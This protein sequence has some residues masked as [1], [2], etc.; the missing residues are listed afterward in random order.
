MT[1]PRRVT[2][3]GIPVGIL[4]RAQPW[5]SGPVRPEGDPPGAARA[6]RLD[7][8]GPAAPLAGGIADRA[9]LE[10]TLRV[11]AA[12]ADAVTRDE[13][14]DAIVAHVGG[15]VG[16]SS[17]AVFLV[18]D[19]GA[20]AR[21]ARTAGY[22]DAARERL[23][24]LPLDVAGRLPALDCLRAGEPLWIDSQAALLERYPHL[25][26]LVTPGRSYRIACLPLIGHGATLGALALTFDDAPALD[27]EERAFLLLCAR[28]SAQAVERLRLHEAERR[29]RERAELLYGLVHEVIVASRAEDVFAAALDAIAR[30]LGAERASILTYGKDP[31]MRFRAWRG[32]SDAY[33]AAVDGHS[34]WTR[35]IRDPAPIV[36]ADVEADPAAAPYRSIFRAE[37][38]GALAFIPLVAGRELVGKFMVYYPAPRA[39][40]ADEL[41]LARAI[42]DHVAA[43]IARFAAVGELEDAIRFND[44]FIAILGH[45]LRNPLAAI[46]TAAQL[47]IVRGPTEAMRKPLS[48]IVASGLRMARMIEQ[49]LDLTRV[50]AGGGIPV[51]AAD[52]DLVPVARAVIDEIDGA[53]PGRTIELAQL[54]D[55]VGRWDGDR[56]AQ[57]FSNLIA[58][59]VQHGDAAGGVRVQIDG[60]R[61]DAVRAE[62]HNAGAI[63]PERLPG[64]FEPLGGERRRAAGARGLGLGL[65]ITR[66]IVQAHGGTI[67]VRSDVASG[68]TFTIV[69]PRTA[70]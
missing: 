1:Q 38:I 64:L 11:T 28:Y 16:A 15:A 29:S 41:D 61:P 4:R 25:A 44:M 30:A 62:V 5:Q 18:D 49:L 70:R 54:G 35:D 58:N 23:A 6:E 51:T 56:L 26:S 57:V 10:R 48:L 40:G 22:G 33:R 36:I 55:T 24:V 63:G 21:L 69:L 59:A 7:R 19:G 53:N 50:R 52:V 67:D 27:D 60:S 32:L 31:A 2:G 8:A 3:F 45:D 34:P 13:V 37:G 65:H 46:V 68:T 20:V 43:A 14:L 17:A 39:L 9:D 47:G 66:A 12:I 42:A